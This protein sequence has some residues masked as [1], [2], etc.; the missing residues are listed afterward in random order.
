M[1]SFSLRYE[2]YGFILEG[3]VFCMSVKACSLLAGLFSLLCIGVLLS[4]EK[5]LAIAI[6]SALITTTN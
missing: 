4:L 6:I 3:T 1:L 5:E 2:F